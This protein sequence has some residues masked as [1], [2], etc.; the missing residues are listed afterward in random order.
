[1]EVAIVS[2]LTW[3]AGIVSLVAVYEIAAANISGLKL[4]SFLP[5]NIDNC[6][7]GKA[8]G[9]ADQVGFDANHW[10]FTCVR[11]LKNGDDIY[12]GLK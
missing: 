4:P 12:I 6:V 11:R 5:G 8:K 2:K 1:V 3:A 9:E 7:V 10:E